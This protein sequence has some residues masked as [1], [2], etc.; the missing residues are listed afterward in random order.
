MQWSTT[1]SR[2]ARRGPTR[3]ARSLQR[4][5]RCCYCRLC[6]HGPS[7]AT[8][9]QRPGQRARRL[10]AICGQPRGLGNSVRP[11]HMPERRE[12]GTQA[13]GRSYEPTTILAVAPFLHVR[14]LR[15]DGSDK[16]LRPR[17]RLARHLLRP[18]CFERAVAACRG[19]IVGCEPWMIMSIGIS[20]CSERSSTAMRKSST[21]V[22]GGSLELGELGGGRKAHGRDGRGGL[23]ARGRG[24]GRTRW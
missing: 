21:W 14:W 1:T 17:R 24:A 8:W 5:S 15:C 10:P 3:S 23:V 18:A 20:A 13:R 22:G 16:G 19:G 12:T 4:R 11:R 2:S 6:A 9:S 7:G